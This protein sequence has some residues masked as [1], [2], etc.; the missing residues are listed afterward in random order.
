MLYHSHDEYCDNL[1]SGKNV[2]DL[3]AFKNITS[4]PCSFW[5]L[6]WTTKPAVEHRLADPNATMQPW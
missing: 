1:R 5:P 3:K 4:E 2:V 6:H